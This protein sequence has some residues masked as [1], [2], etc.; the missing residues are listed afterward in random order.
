[1]R[2]K[3]NLVR[4]TIHHVGE[5]HLNLSGFNKAIASIEFGIR[6]LKN[7]WP[8]FQAILSTAGKNGETIFLYRQVI[9]NNDN[10]LS[11]VLKELN[12]KDTEFLVV[13]SKEISDL[14]VTEN[15]NCTQ[16]VTISE[17]ALN[18]IPIICSVIENFVA[19]HFSQTFPASDS[20]PRFIRKH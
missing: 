14:I 9:I 15:R 8:H 6:F 18:D 10:L 19:L 2:F 3:Q 17:F 20:S 5:C 7:A 13:V 12:F 11:S 1:V 16:E 4:E